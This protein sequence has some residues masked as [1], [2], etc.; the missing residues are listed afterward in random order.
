MLRSIFGSFSI[1]EEKKLLNFSLSVP[2]KRPATSR[3]CRQQVP[4]QLIEVKLSNENKPPHRYKIVYASSDLGDDN[5]GVPFSPSAIEQD[6]KLVTRHQHR[7]FSSE[8]WSGPEEVNMFGEH[9]Q[10]T[11]VMNVV[12]CPQ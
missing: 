5:I 2:S 1:V 9:T 10:L 3:F 11:D 4:P 6:A 7:D 12:T 8:T